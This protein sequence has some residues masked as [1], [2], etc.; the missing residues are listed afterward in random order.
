MGSE[1]GA[2][3]SWTWAIAAPTLLIIGALVLGDAQRCRA[4]AA[5]EAGQAA[6][7]ASAAE[8]APGARSP[9]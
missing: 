4:A 1:R 8:S 7:A 5:P 6:A 9:H 2:L 3:S